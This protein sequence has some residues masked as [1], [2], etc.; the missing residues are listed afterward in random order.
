[1][2]KNSEIF[3]VN[4]Q[5]FPES[6]SLNTLQS[7]ILSRMNFLRISGDS[8]LKLKTQSFLFTFIF[9]CDIMIEKGIRQNIAFIYIV[10]LNSEY[11]N[12]KM[13]I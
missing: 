8:V 10:Y 11:V 7:S 2:S 6:Q 1:M 5:L 4:M 3:P 9:F 13:P 12:S